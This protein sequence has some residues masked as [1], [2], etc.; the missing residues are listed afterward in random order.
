MN[1]Y[2]TNIIKYI[3]PSAIKNSKIPKQ[4][5]Q[6]TGLEVIQR[7]I[8]ISTP[9]FLDDVIVIVSVICFC[10]EEDNIKWQALE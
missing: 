10:L 4:A 3:W 8:L 9:L 2:K 5:Y 7:D 1:K 6:F